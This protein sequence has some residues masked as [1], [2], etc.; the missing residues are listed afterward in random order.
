MATVAA[1]TPQPS[2]TNDANSRSRT[3]RVGGGSL[4]RLGSCPTPTVPDELTYLAGYA[5]PQLAVVV[6]GE[7]ALHLADGISSR[8]D[9]RVFGPFWAVRDPH[10]KVGNLSGFALG[11]VCR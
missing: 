2:A 6:K 7:H 3:L 5:R 11:Y 10:E 4:I 8:V 9:S 1:A